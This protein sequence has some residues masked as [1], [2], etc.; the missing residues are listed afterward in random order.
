MEIKLNKEENMY[1]YKHKHG[2]TCRGFQSLFDEANQLARL[3]EAHDLIP[4]TDEWGTLAT[5]VKHDQL[6]KL[7]KGKNLGT[8]FDS[9]TPAKVRKVLEDARC[10]A[11]QLRIFNGDTKT[12]RDW[13]E[14][15]DV[16]G[17]IGRSTGILKIPL[18]IAEGEDGGPALLDHCIVRIMDLEGK[19]LYSHPSYHHGE[20]GVHRLEK[21]NDYAAM[22]TVD[23]NTYA[24]FPTLDEAYHWLAYMSGKSFLPL[25]QD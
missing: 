4:T 9:R 5:Q 10:N 22:V 18:L 23:G 13:L 2:V 1:V 24:N 7:A 6:I 19:I 15:C 8:F 25:C 14:E 17:H 21:G 20:F 16:Q 11:T 12:G 3:L